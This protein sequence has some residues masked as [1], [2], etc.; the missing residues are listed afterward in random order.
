M[1]AYL[2]LFFSFLDL[3]L[4][5]RLDTSQAGCCSVL[6]THMYSSLAL[7]LFFFSEPAFVPRKADTF[8]TSTCTIVSLSGLIRVT[9]NTHIGFD[10]ITV[11]LSLFPLRCRCPRRDKC[12]Q[13]HRESC[14]IEWSRIDSYR[15]E[16]R[17]V[18]VMSTT[19]GRRRRRRRRRQR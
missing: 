13:R 10:G 18:P 19:Y 7:P 16:A 4:H 1:K 3:E 15:K 17:T 8:T 14:W 12:Y 9:I 2:K 11:S 5:P 6:R